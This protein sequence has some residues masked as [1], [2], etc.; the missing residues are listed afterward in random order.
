ME[1]KSKIDLDWNDKEAV[2]LKIIL[3]KSAVTGACTA[4]TKLTKRAYIFST[5]PAACEAARTQLETTWNFCAQLH[6]RQEDLELKDTKEIEGATTQ[7][8]E[9]ATAQA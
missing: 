3:A 6:D 1:G 5:P 2:K 9:G 8:I 4:I 7:E